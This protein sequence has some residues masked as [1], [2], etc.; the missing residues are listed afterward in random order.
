MITKE[1]IHRGEGKLVEEN[2]LIG[3]RNITSQSGK[4]ASKGRLS[5]DEKEFQK[6]LFAMSEM[7]KVLYEDYL[8]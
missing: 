4:M 6:T 8:E 3:L 7:M 2:S 1:N 5:Q